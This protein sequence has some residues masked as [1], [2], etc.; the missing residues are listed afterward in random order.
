MPDK[1]PTSL[2]H[3][4]ILHGIVRNEKV[5]L[6]LAA[7]II[8]GQYGDIGLLDQEPLEITECDGI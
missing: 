4:K 6:E 2:N 8:R 7:A 3:I 5:A 1:S